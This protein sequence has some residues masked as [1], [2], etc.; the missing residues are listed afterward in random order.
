[1]RFLKSTLALVALCSTSVVR[2]SDHLINTEY[3]GAVSFNVTKLYKV[4]VVR[5]LS[6]ESCVKL[7]FG[8]DPYE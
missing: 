8:V 5:P 4:D 1:M 7:N 2:K 3:S 6:L